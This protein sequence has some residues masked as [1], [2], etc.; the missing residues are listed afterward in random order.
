MNI[1]MII[2]AWALFVALTPG[3]LIDLPGIGDPMTVAIVH[4]LI[5]AVLYSVSHKQ[6]WA[7]FNK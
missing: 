5:F 6:V 7:F 4:G 1:V 2:F 3:I